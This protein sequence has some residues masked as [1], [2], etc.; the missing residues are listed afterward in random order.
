MLTQELK[1]AATAAFRDNAKLSEMSPGERE[2][3]AQGYEQVAQQ[4]VGTQV[5]LARL[6]NLERA[7]FLRGQVSRIAS[8]A[9]DFANEI[10]YQ[11]MTGTDLSGDWGMFKFSEGACVALKNDNPQLGLV[12]G[13]TGVVWALYETQPPA[14]EVTFRTQDGEEFDA[15]TY[16]EELTEP[17]A[18]REAAVPSVE[19]RLA[20]A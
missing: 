18:G 6:Y 16:E 5:G 8:K 12:A 14:Y 1:N 3:A 19:R 13:D 15:L 4:M 2:Q 9:R 10:G 7:K 20:V 17:A 11:E